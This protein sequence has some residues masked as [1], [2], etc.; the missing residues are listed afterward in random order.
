MKVE[1]RMLDVEYVEF[2]PDNPRISEYLRTYEDVSELDATDIAMALQPNDAKY[3]ELKQA[4]RTNEG[5]INPII[6][7]QFTGKLI[8]I[9][10]NTRLAVYKEFHED[11]PDDET[12][13]HIPAIVYDDMSKTAIDAVRLQAHLVGVRNW[14]PY[15]K[16]KYL[17]TLHEKDHLPLNSLVDFCGGNKLEVVRNIEAFKRMEHDFRPLVPDDEFDQHK[18]SNFLEV[19]KKSSISKALLKA[20]F[21]HKDFASWVRNGKFE[22]RQELVR[23][24]PEILS[25]PRA[26]KVFLEDGA[27]KALIYIDRPEITEELKKASLIEL[28]AA[29]QEKIDDLTLKERDDIRKSDDSIQS[30]DD[31]LSYL[32]NFYNNEI[33]QE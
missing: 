6:V 25:N 33:Q 28:C 5:I 23:K 12:W 10:G 11:N 7:N 18:F 3:I 16:A 24:L 27:D 13:S 19:Q 20:G 31:T 17:Y 15:A 29:V 26:R 9:E 2:D 30:I 8:A 32:S 4:I 21:N 1:H 22:P 14:T